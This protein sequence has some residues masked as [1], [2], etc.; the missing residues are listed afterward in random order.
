[1]RRAAYSA[2]VMLRES[3]Q[4]LDRLGSSLQ[5]AYAYKE[6]LSRHRQIMN[7][8]DRK[9]II[10]TDVFIAPSASII[11][12]VQLHPSSSVFYGCVLRGD[13]SSITLGEGANIQ[14]RAVVHTTR[15]LHTSNQVTNVT[16]GALATICQ[17]A[18]IH[19]A[20]IHAEAYVGMGAVISPGVSVRK[21]AMVAAGSYVP[22][23]TTVKEGELWA[24]APASFVRMLEKE[25]IEH[26]VE[27]AKVLI[28][29]AQAHAQENGKTHDQ[30]EGEILRQTLLDQRSDDYH[31]HIGV[32]GREEEI[33]EIQAKLIEEDR[34]EQAKAGQSKQ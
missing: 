26:M 19:A 13:H 32:T 14:D 6:Q 29:L 33:V 24:G 9:P 31:S 23:G 34:A 5:G 22:P 8:M 18:S 25:E 7:L 20:N 21:H 2:G 10:G 16:I 15:D 17:G 4:A 1:M 27:N 3:G 30:I 28:T 12:E 11:G